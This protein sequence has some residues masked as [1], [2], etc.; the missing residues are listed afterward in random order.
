MAAIMKGMKKYTDIPV[1]ALVIF[2]VLHDQGPWIKNHPDP[3]V[4]EAAKARS[5]EEAVLVEKQAKAFENG[6]TS[7]PVLRLSGPNHYVFLTNQADVLLQIT[8]CISTP[9]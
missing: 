5:D 7:A 6:V 3:A 4:R 1:P 9:R 2:A 8:S